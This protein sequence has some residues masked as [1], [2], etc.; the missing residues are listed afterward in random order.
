M[1]A[2]TKN[3][4]NIALNMKAYRL[5]HN[6]K[7]KEI[8][9]LLEMN[10]QNYSK[11]E[12]GLYTPSLEKLIDICDILNLT[13][14][15]LLMEGK[16]FDDYKQ[17]VFEMLDVNVLNIIDTMKIVEE[18]RAQALKAKG[19]RDEK[20]ERFHL[21]RIIGMFAWTNEHMW[22][23]ADYLYYK[24]LNEHIKKTSDSLLDNMKKIVHKEAFDNAQK[25]RSDKEE[26]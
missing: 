21:D 19:E 13:P 12:R 26:E 2:R 17:E 6:M 18:E 4:S 10:H 25:Q 11:M 14:N 23:V 20:S 24:K 3:L 9:D 16:N 15:D 5:K 1:F 8:A 22:E 7:Q